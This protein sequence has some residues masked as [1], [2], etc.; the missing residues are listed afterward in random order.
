MIQE[1]WKHEITSLL[2]GDVDKEIFFAIFVF[3]F[4]VLADILSACLHYL[5]Q[6][7]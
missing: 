1:S 6:H 2:Q 5:L 3:A 4:T 7:S